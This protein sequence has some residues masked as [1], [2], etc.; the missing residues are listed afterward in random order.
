MR[1]PSRLKP[2]DTIG[3]VSP[4]W[5]GAGAFPHRVEQ[6]IKHLDTLG[7]KVKLAPHALNQ[8]GF[9]SDTPANR[10]Q[11]IHEMFADPAITEIETP[12]VLKK[13]QEDKKSNSPGE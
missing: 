2:G 5:G 10:A 11:D 13:D 1:K 3:I 4:S 6:G 12:V 7:F 8:N 9:V